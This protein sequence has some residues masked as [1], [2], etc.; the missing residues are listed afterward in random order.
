MWGFGVVQPQRSPATGRRPNPWFKH[1]T[2][3]WRL[4]QAAIA[5]GDTAAAAAYRKQFNVV[6]RRWKRHYTKQHLA[7][8]RDAYQHNP[9]KFWLFFK[10]ARKQ[11]FLR[12]VH[13]WRTYWQTLYGGQG[14]EHTRLPRELAELERFCQCISDDVVLRDRARAA[15]FNAPIT[16]AEVGS[17]FSKLARGKAAGP[18]GIRGELLRDAVVG[19]ELV[20]PA[21]GIWV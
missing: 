11:E 16:V 19:V 15:V 20:S 6:K 3:E 8:L 21:V 4:I 18:D 10:G 1:C 2:A 13:A 5:R 12:D 17:V 9:R 14:A 7:Y